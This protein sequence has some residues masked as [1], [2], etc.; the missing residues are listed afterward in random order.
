M[1]MAL[2][3]VITVGITM[4]II[5]ALV[6]AMGGAALAMDTCRVGRSRTSLY[7]IGHLLTGRM[8]TDP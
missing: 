6:I 4:G 7:V 3:M 2:L 5:M 1:D 8:L